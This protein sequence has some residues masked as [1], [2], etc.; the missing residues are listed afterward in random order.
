MTTERQS[1]SDLIAEFR[2]NEI[3]SAAADLVSREGMER[4]TMERVAAL[5]GIAK[6]TV[7]IYFKDKEELIRSLLR[8]TMTEVVDAV[9]DVAAGDLELRDRLLRIGHTIREV[10]EK[11]L[12][13]LVQLHNMDL[14]HK[15]FLEDGC[16]TTEKRRLFDFMET[17][18]RDSM[19]RGE[20]AKLD[21]G[22][23]SL[24]FL[25]SMH[26]MFHWCLEMREDATDKVEFVVDMF[27]HG[28]HRSAG[29]N[30]A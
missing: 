16:G 8:R 25:T 15:R 1:R 29:N 17:V 9:I 4:L 12:E 18:F 7:Y 13:I 19:E 11:H 24:L 27:I 26:A 6:G 3:L 10:S 23:L 2:T 28:I 20:I 21:P 22:I 30:N 14:T 5:A